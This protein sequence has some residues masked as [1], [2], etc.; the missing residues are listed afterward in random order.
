MIT[1]K[2][3]RT[4]FVDIDDTLIMH[5][6]PADRF[7]ENYLEIQDPLDQNK[8]IKV[9]I[10]RPMV[11]L[12]KEEAHRGSYIVVWSRGGWEWAKAVVLALRLVDSVG[13]IMTKPFAYFDDTDV[14]VWMKDRVYIKPDV[15]YKREVEK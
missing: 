1:V 15:D 14:S 11:R 9:T 6:G 2:N 3:E 5:D 13:Q 12:V 10:N 4:I 7:H 8:Y